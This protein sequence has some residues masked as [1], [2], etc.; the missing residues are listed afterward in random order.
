MILSMILPIAL[1]EIWLLYRI[2]ASRT[3]SA[4]ALNLPESV[5]NTA[6]TRLTFATQLL[7]EL[8]L[9]NKTIGGIASFMVGIS[10]GL[11]AS[12]TL[13]L[14]A[15]SELTMNVFMGISMGIFLI[16]TLPKHIA[17]LLITPVLVSSIMTWLYVLTR[18]HPVS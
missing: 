10:A 2:M 12:R 17:M 1:L 9:H 11:L 16:G 6:L 14:G 8:L 18:P 7:V 4:P 3:V 13:H 15:F 5:T